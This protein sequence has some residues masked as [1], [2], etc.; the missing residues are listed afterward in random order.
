VTPVGVEADLASCGDG[1]GKSV[2]LAVTEVVAN[3]PAAR[4]AH[5]RVRT[6]AGNYDHPYVAA[7][8]PNARPRIEVSKD[9]I[10]GGAGPRHPVGTVLR[11]AD[12]VSP[13]LPVQYDDRHR[14]ARVSRNRDQRA[15]Q[16]EATGDGGSHIR[17]NSRSSRRLPSGPNRRY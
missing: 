15:K 10:G 1:D 8:P 6:P 3:L 2:R 16:R 7:G 14:P 9:L 4:E 12:A 11:H 5:H 17:N 13:P